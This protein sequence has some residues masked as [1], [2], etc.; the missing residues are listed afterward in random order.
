[1]SEQAWV[2][3]LAGGESQEAL[4]GLKALA[5]RVAEAQPGI[6]VRG[7]VLGGKPGLLPVIRRLQR[8]GYDEFVLVP[9]W[10][11]QPEGGAA[12]LDRQF[13]NS[14][15]LRPDIR[16]KLGPPLPLA[17]DLVAGIV[18]SAAAARPVDAVERGLPVATRRARRRRVPPPPYEKLALVCTGYTCL[19]RGS[20]ELS[21]RL[22][23]VLDEAHVAG[24]RVTRTNCLGPC[25]SGPVMHVATDGT[26]YG[27]LAVEDARRVAL[28]HLALGAP[29]EDLRIGKR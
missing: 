29:C 26:W 4:S 10:Y 11:A 28:E 16:L 24:V 13:L 8:S 22:T 27:G 2:L 21:H 5:D 17:L 25:T 18:E 3:M 19:G 9:L 7:A 15:R 6:P 20:M 23:A 14:Q 1:M 12:D